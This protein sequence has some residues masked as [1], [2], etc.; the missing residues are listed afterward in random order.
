MKALAA[1]LIASAIL[2]VADSEYNQGRYAAVIQRA[3]SSVI[4][5]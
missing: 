1:A 5:G 3:V 4:P 2:Y